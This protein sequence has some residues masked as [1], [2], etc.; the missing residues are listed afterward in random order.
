MN[1]ILVIDDSSTLRT[2]IEY[3]LKK[4]GHQIMQAENGS[5]ALDEINEIKKTGGEIKL[6]VCDVNMPIMD[7]LSFVREFRKDDKFTPILMLTTE[8]GEDMLKRG[9]DAGASGWMIKPFRP[10][11]LVQVVE[12]LIH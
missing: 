4:F 3:A 6:C 12:K 1:Y 9:K 10:A 11:E 5:I 8:T 2:S 7:G